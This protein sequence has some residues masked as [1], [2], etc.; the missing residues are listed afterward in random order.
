MIVLGYQ[1][2]G[3]SSLARDRN[4]YVDLESGNFFVNGTRHDDWYM[5]YCRI[6]ENLS[7]QGYDVFTS[8]HAVV[9]EELRR[10]CATRK[11]IVVPALCLKE[12]WIEK[13]R[14][15]WEHSGKDKDYRAYMNAADRYDA[16]ITELMS[17]EGFEIVVLGSMDY[18]LDTELDRVRA[19]ING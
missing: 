2:I 17:T 5:P 4:G 10:I 14:V 3:K 11:I 9:R 6:A 19:R 15:R 16:N 12:P 18:E 7:M 8:S 13:L 1:G